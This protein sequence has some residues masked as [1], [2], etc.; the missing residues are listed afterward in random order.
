MKADTSPTIHAIHEMGYR[1]SFNHHRTMEGRV[2]TTCA[3]IENSKERDGRVFFGVS[4]CSHKDQ[5][6][7]RKGNRIALG[8]AWKK[9]VAAK[10]ASRGLRTIPMQLVARGQ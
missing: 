9:I 1:T 5:W 2:I 8:R 6:N 3:I 7:R 4:D 10:S